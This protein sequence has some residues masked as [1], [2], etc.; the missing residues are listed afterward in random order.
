MLHSQLLPYFEARRGQ[1]NGVVFFDW[2][3]QVDGLIE[4]FLNL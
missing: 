3:Q 2:Y 4:A 1:R